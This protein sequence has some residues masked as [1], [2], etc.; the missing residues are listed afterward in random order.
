MYKEIV[1]KKKNVR[2]NKNGNG[3]DVSREGVE[4][5]E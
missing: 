1:H 4:M 2:L 5:N 3:T